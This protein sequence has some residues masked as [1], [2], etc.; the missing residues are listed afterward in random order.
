MNM[1]QPKILHQWLFGCVVGLLLAVTQSFALAPGDLVIVGF[2]A[3]N[4]DDLSFVVL[5]DVPT[6]TIVYFRDNEWNGSAFVDTG[7]GNVRWNSGNSI[8]PKGTVVCFNNITATETTTHG[9][10][11]ESSAFDISGS[12]D[13]IFVFHGT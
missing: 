7:E 3:D 9:T 5:V 1:H 12:G 11:L 10:I 2:N 8:I 6:N 13:G 4:N